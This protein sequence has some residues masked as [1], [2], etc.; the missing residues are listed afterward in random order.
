MLVTR[1]SGK[2][3]QGA[4]KLYG[5]ASD[6]ALEAIGT[7]FLANTVL[8]T[9]VRG[10][11]GRFALFA[12][13]MMVSLCIMA[14]G[15]ITGGSLNPARTLGPAIAIGDYSQIS[16]Y[17]AAQVTGAVMAE[18]LYRFVWKQAPAANRSAAVN[19]AVNEPIHITNA[20][21]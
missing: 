18:L 19:E 5:L 9:A 1:C 15:P 8:N 13:G 6:F 3:Q 16:I 17:L 7:F 10:T 12:I 11:A 2:P 20:G 4:T 14:F 21:E